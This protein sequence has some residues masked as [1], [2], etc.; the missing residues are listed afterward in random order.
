MRFPRKASISYWKVFEVTIPTG[1]HKGKQP[2]AS[3][4]PPKRTF[5]EIP[6]VVVQVGATKYAG[7]HALVVKD[8]FDHNFN[9]LSVFY[10][11]FDVE[12]ETGLVEHWV[13]S[14][15]ESCGQVL[16]NWRIEFGE[17]MGD[18]Q[19]EELAQRMNLSARHFYHSPDSLEVAR[20]QCGLKLPE[21]LPCCFGGDHDTQLAVKPEHVKRLVSHI[22]RCLCQTQELPRYPDSD[23]VVEDLIEGGDQAKAEV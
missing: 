1:E 5:I 11:E 14:P 16:M 7:Q 23:D 21:E 4:Y 6:S 19:Y 10:I 3:F 9:T 22:L 8:W 20:R 17:G 12:D 13:Q 18:P 15:S 2:D